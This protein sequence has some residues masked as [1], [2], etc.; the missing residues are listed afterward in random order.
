LQTY[1]QKLVVDDRPLAM[2]S[3]MSVGFV[4]ERLKSNLGSTADAHLHASRFFGEMA[5]HAPAAQF[6]MPL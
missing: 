2:T 6:N 4:F 3:H 5:P 1:Q